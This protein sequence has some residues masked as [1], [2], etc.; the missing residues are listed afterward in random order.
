[1][2][3]STKL[4]AP[5]PQQNFSL[6]GQYPEIGG[7]EGDK[8]SDSLDRVVKSQPYDPVRHHPKLSGYLAN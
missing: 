6:F 7:I 1:M 8:T 4:I 3:G 2:P 5:S